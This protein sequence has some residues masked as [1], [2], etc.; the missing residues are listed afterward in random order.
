MNKFI[1]YN[2]QDYLVPYIIAAL[3]VYV[4]VG[5]FLPSWKYLHDRIIS[6]RWEDWAY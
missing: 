3:P 5:I 6:L 2:V 4:R 1:L